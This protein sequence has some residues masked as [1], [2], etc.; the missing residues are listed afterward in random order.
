[1]RTRLF[2]LSLYTFFNNTLF[3]RRVILK[4]NTRIIRGKKYL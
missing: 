3:I 1:M 4:H 2:Q